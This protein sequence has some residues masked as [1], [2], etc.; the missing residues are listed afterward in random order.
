MVP[1]HVV[2]IARTDRRRSRWPVWRVPDFAQ[3]ACAHRA[4]RNVKRPRFRCPPFAGPFRHRRRS[5]HPEFHRG[6][7]A[8]GA[9][10][11]CPVDETVAAAA[12]WIGCIT[13]EPA[14]FRTTVPFIG[15][16][17]GT[18]AVNWSRSGSLPLARTLVAGATVPTVS[19]QL[20][21][22]GLERSQS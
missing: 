2:S 15:S 11:I 3:T 19:S 10:V 7:V 8:I 16:V 18:A 6:A 5:V 9:A 14:E 4:E 1:Q 13:N 20:K 17:A 22:F 21:R 12:V